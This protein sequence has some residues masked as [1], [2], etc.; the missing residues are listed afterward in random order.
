MSTPSTPR[1]R[2]VT[3]TSTAKITPQEAAV[4]LRIL[5]KHD[6]GTLAPETPFPERE[7]ISRLFDK[8][9]FNLRE[10]AEQEVVS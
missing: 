6:G 10:L 8:L 5:Q 7:G 4:M 2:G 1:T 3:H 9:R